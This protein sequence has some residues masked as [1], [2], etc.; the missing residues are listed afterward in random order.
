M[1]HSNL[2]FAALPV[3]FDHTFL[4][5]EDPCTQFESFSLFL[6]HLDLNEYFPKNEGNRNGSFVRFHT[7][8]HIFNLLFSPKVV[9]FGFLH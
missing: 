8:N 2:D 7:S 4:I 1:L 5:A 6:H 3:N 9:H